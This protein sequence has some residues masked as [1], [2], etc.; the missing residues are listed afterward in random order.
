MSVQ[1]VRA[2]T[3]G[4]AMTPRLDGRTDVIVLE[5]RLVRSGEWLVLCL[6]P[7]NTVTPFV[8]WRAYKTA[9]GWLTESGTYCQ[10]VSAAVASLAKRV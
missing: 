1:E 9:D 2:L 6:L 4:E 5:A 10:S 3:P 8:T 7:S